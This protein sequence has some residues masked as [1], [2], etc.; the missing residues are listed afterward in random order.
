METQKLH[1][2]D[3]TSINDLSQLHHPGVDTAP[4]ETTVPTDSAPVVSD[5]E[6]PKEDK[7]KRSMIKKDVNAGK[8]LLGENPPAEEIIDG[9]NLNVPQEEVPSTD[10]PNDEPTP[11]K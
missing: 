10:T 4:V 1:P 8:A 6:T 11:V 2:T 5:S 3:G 7:P 9:S